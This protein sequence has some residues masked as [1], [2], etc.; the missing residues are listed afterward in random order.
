VKL[1]N[2]AAFQGA[3]FACVIGAA[4]GW[5][6]VGAAAGLALLALHFAWFTHDRRGDAILAA[7][8]V[9]Y[10]A[11]ADSLASALGRID[12]VAPLPGGLAPVWILVLWAWFAATQQHSMTW[13]RTRPLLAVALGGVGGP[14]SYL[15]GERLGALRFLEPRAQGLALGAVVFGLATYGLSRLALRLGSAHAQGAGAASGRDVR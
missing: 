13:L 4:K 15:A 10:G 6:G 2:F 1:V 11:V 9:A 14:L 5:P 7:V 12:Y 3:W 8:A